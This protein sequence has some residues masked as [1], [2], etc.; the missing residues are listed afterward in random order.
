MDAALTGAI[1][2]QAQIAMLMCF[3]IPYILG[4]HQLAQG[5]I[6]LGRTQRWKIKAMQIAMQTHDGWQPGRQMQVGS[7]HLGAV[8]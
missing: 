5:N 2:L 8:A 7:P 3:E 1:P 6:E 4:L